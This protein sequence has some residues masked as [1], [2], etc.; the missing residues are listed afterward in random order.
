[1]CISKKESLLVD[2]EEDAKGFY[3]GAKTL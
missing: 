2:E 3:L 1:M